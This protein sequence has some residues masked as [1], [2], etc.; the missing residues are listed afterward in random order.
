MVKLYRIGKYKMSKSDKERKE[1]KN[2]HYL[3]II[4]NYS[5]K[6]FQLAAV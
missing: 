6:A 2:I 4:A 3:V 1:K 5:E